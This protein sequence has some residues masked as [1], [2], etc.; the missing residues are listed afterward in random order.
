[1]QTQ[2][3]LHTPE[4]MRSTTSKAHRV[5]T[6]LPLVA[7]TLCEQNMKEMCTD[8]GPALA[9]VGAPFTTT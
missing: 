2:V 9:T 6:R 1:M 4:S 7:E 8:V 3:S 5:T